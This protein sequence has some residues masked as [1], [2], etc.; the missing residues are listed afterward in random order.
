MSCLIFKFCGD[1]Y[2]SYVFTVVYCI[3]HLPMSLID[4]I[5]PYHI[6]SIV[7]CNVCVTYHNMLQYF[8]SISVPYRSMYLCTSIIYSS[9]Q[10][11]ATHWI[12]LFVPKFQLVHLP[13]S[14]CYLLMAY[15]LVAILLCLQKDISVFLKPFNELTP[16]HI[17]LLYLWQASSTLAHHL[18]FYQI[19]DVSYHIQRSNIICVM[20][21]MPLDFSRIYSNH[22]S[23]SSISFASCTGVSIQFGGMWLYIQ[24]SS[25]LQ[26]IF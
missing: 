7:M 15:F 9:A 2:S 5:S 8:L 23:T 22:A 14:V 6:M 12:S 16:C 26:R 4:W 10:Q 3:C 25:V 20:L 24:G 13:L 18:L 11:T 17:H 1:F 19:I 21:F